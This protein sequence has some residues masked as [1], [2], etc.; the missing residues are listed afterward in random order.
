LTVV[1]PFARIALQRSLDD[2]DTIKI[3][4][5]IRAE[6]AAGRDPLPALVAAPTAAAAA[7][8]GS[9]AS[10]VPWESDSYLQPV[11]AD[12]PLLTYEYDEGVAATEM[13][14]LR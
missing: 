10:A 3:I 1:L 7:A 8:G 5:F 13:G 14:G 2:Y 11:L 9:D 4:N 12:D 6:V